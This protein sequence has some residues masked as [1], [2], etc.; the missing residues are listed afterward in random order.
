M[1]APEDK[2]HVTVRIMDRDF[3]V[4]CP[5]D[6]ISALHKAAKFLDTRIREFRKNDQVISLDNLAI[7]TALNITH[8]LLNQRR[9]NLAYIDELHREIKNIQT[10]IEEALA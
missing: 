9:E 2:N 3:S 10:T 6:K 8:D 1:S 4:T 7:I 5:N